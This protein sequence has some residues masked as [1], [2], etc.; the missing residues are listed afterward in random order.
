LIC[1]C[2]SVLASFFAFAI[3]YTKKKYSLKNTR[4]GGLKK[5]ALFIDLIQALDKVEGIERFRISS[6]EPNLCSDDIIEFVAASNR[7]VPHFHMPLQSGNNKQLA[8]MRRR[9]RRELYAERVE[10]IKHLMPHACIGVDVIV[11]FPSETDDDFEETYNFIKNM[12][13]SYLHIFTYSERPNTPA[14]DMD[15]IP[16]HIRK[17]RNQHLQTLSSDKKLAFYQ[18]H[19][20]ESRKVLIEGTADEDFLHGF[21]DNY[22]KVKVDKS[23]YRV[24]DIV[25]L[26]LQTIDQD[27]MVRA[28]SSTILEETTTV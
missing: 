12:D 16:M 23:S 26:Q 3:A 1:F 24:N 8:D 20:G 7:F 25:D 21:T 2:S 5:E 18:Q 15:Q 28:V 13:I 17:E 11:G 9:Y 27:G 22:I 19:L 14:I 6:I 10:K 4:R